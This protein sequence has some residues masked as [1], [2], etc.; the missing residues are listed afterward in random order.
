[1]DCTGL[2]DGD[3]VA[4]RATPE[5]KNSDVVV[6]RFGDEVTLKRFGRLNTRREELPARP[7]TI[8]RTRRLQSTSPSTS[9]T[10]TG[11]RWGRSS[12]AWAAQETEHRARS[13]FRRTIAHAVPNSVRVARPIRL[14]AMGRIR[15]TSGKSATRPMN[16]RNPVIDQTPPSDPTNTPIINAPYE[17]PA[18][19][20]S[21][22]NEFRACEPP[23]PG[24]RPSG[25]YLS[26]PR[27]RK[28]QGALDLTNGHR[29][30]QEIEPHRHECLTGQRVR[31]WL[32]LLGYPPSPTLNYPPGAGAPLRDWTVR[33]RALRASGQARSCV[34]MNHP[35][36]IGATGVHQRGDDLAFFQRRRGFAPLE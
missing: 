22:D 32:T 3:V 24:R 1:M 20:W 15:G 13:E 27:P 17:T 10:S 36:L 29:S 21:L 33:P 23:L 11:S 26:V 7:A 30:C 8:R 18:W 25:A 12:G 14:G 19:H 34:K 31:D 9:C 5:A 16:G 4:I 2:R 28:K 6:A 35:I